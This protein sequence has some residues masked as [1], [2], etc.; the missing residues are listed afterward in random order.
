MG[1]GYTG[2]TVGIEAFASPIYEAVSRATSNR[3][4]FTHLGAG[5]NPRLQYHLRFYPK[6]LRLPK[7]E[8]C[9]CT[10]GHGT[11][12]V[13]YSMSKGAANMLIAEII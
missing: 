3:R 7:D 2:C 11:N 1:R 6:V 12:D 4:G 8:V 9:E 13:R 5:D 10:D